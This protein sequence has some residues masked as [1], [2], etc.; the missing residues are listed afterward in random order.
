VSDK[1]DTGLVVV[2][3]PGGVLRAARESANISVEEMAEQLNWLKSYVGAIEED[4]YSAFS[5]QTFAKGYL[6]SYARRLGV[7]E[8][9]LLENY[10]KLVGE[11]ESTSQE[12]VETNI[13]TLHKSGIGKYVGLIVFLLVIVVLWLARSSEDSTQGK[14]IVEKIDSVTTAAENQ[15]QLGK[16]SEEQTDIRSELAVV[17]ASGQE[18]EDLVL[19]QP[20]AAVPTTDRDTA[21]NEL[22]EDVAEVADQLQEDVEYS[23]ASVDET[24]LTATGEHVLYFSFSAECWL[25]VR[26]ASGDVI[27]EDLRQSGDNISVSGLPPFEIL[28]GQA[29]AVELRYQNELVSLKADSGRNSVRRRIGE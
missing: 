23:N 27:Y 9:G 19:E 10:E 21:L 13:P 12:T 26:D 17:E 20:E 7:E 16:Q 5:N 22:A 28:A 14:A 24:V 6:K 15:A 8:Q 1:S 11:N 4:Q 18:Q 2:E 29:S 3:S 25:E